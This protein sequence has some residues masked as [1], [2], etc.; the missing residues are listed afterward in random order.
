MHGDSIG[1]FGY[2]DKS[3]DSI[4][5]SVKQIGLPFFVYIYINIGK[6]DHR[7][8]LYKDDIILFVSRPEESLPPLLELIESF[9]EISGYTINW[10]KSE[11]MP[12]KGDLNPEFL[13]HIPFK[14]TGVKGVTRG[15]HP[16]GP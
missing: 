7:I 5:A 8:L 4:I 14:V 9:G 15:C 1:G 16:Q 6:V 3:T 10:D 11:F 12:L 13:K 2:T